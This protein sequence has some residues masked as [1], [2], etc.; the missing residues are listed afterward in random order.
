MNKRSKIT[1]FLVSKKDHIR[2]YG[3]ILEWGRLT[4]IIDH[5]NV[6]VHWMSPYVNKVHHFC[7]TI[8]SYTVDFFVIWFVVDIRIVHIHHISYWRVTFDP[9][10]VLSIITNVN[11]NPP[12]DYN[13]TIHDWHKYECQ[14][15]WTIPVRIESQN[16]AS[17]EIVT[18]DR[19][20]HSGH[21]SC[22]H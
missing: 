8:W 13:F 14:Y 2:E 17:H 6:S 21:S 12:C 9:F 11:F 16:V 18:R 22:T 15:D 5:P 4:F 20:T 3:R 1:P 7:I 10:G 19:I